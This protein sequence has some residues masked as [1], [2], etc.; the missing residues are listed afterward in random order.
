MPSTVSDLTVSDLTLHHV[1]EKKTMLATESYSFGHFN[2]LVKMGTRPYTCDGG[3]ECLL[4]SV[5][6]A[7]EG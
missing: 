5:W 1:L 6:T 2:A 3:S 7:F 4:G